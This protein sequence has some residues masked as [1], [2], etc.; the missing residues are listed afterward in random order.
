MQKI[1]SFPSFDSDKDEDFIVSQSNW[2]AYNAIS[3]LQGEW[4][5]LPYKNSL[6]I[7]GSKSSGKTYLAKIWASING[8]KFLSP[9]SKFEISFIQKYNFLIID[10]LDSE[11][12]NEIKLLHY[13][14]IIHEYN[15][16]LLILSSSNKKFSLPDLSS[17]I[18]TLRKIQIHPPDHH[19]IKLLIL[20]KFSYYSVEIRQDTIDFLMKILPRE[21]S[22]LISFI[23]TLNSFSLKLKR[24]ITIPFIKKIYHLTKNKKS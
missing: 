6:L 4:G 13:F 18:M 15:K 11:L 17:R 10:D 22:T 2:E 7:E 20:K 16:K 5:I 8:A 21:Y 23:K 14:N 19:I 3:S 24:K 9:R 12:W 1:F